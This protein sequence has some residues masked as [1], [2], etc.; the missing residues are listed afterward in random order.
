MIG[1]TPTEGVEMYCSGNNLM[2][3]SVMQGRL[4]K[5]SAEYKM[6]HSLWPLSRKYMCY[7]Y[8]CDLWINNCNI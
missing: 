2:N 5:M 1:Q 4:C 6:F 3:Y 7:S 8:I